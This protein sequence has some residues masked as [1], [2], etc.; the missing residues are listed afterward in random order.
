MKMRNLAIFDGSVI[1]FTSVMVPACAQTRSAR[2][3]PQ[4]PRPP[5][6]KK[7]LT[8][9]VAIS[10]ACHERC[11]SAPAPPH[12]SRQASRGFASATLL[13]STCVKSVPGFRDSIAIRFAVN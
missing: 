10:S 9:C 6:T 7:E 8:H 5:L 3:A 11:C 4:E 2:F 12:I 13:S 1:Q